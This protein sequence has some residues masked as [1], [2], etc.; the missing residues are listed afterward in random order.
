MAIEEAYPFQKSICLTVL[1]IQRS[2]GLPVAPNGTSILILYTA[3]KSQ[4][5]FPTK[6]RPE[7]GRWGLGKRKRVGE[8]LNSL[9]YSMP[10]DDSFKN[11]SRDILGRRLPVISFQIHVNSKSTQTASY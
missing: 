5:L 8:R 11:I 7:S 1:E 3:I 2:A 9:W 10:V 6:T 4:T